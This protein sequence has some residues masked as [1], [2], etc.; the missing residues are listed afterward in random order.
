MY[1]HELLLLQLEISDSEQGRGGNKKETR[2]VLCG[3]FVVTKPREGWR[4]KFKERP[5]KE[6]NGQPVAFYRSKGEGSLDDARNC[7]SVV[8]AVGQH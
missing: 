6:I 4:N 3:T 7:R 8:D 2:I 1:S 5:K